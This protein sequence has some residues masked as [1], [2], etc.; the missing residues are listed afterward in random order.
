MK[1]GC[2][3]NRVLIFYRRFSLRLLF[4]FQKVLNDQLSDR[5]LMWDTYTFDFVSRAISRNIM[6][7]KCEN[8]FSLT[9][10]FHCLSSK[11]CGWH[12]WSN[13]FWYEISIKRSLLVR[14]QKWISMISIV[15]RTAEWNSI[16][17][18][19]IRLQNGEMTVLVR[20]YCCCYKNIM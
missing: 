7:L 19:V 11:C 10:F 9:L 13:M 2:T 6:C 12:F 17:C 3:K 14:W 5:T 16:P 4:S 1:I 20:H 15:S 8:K 18:L